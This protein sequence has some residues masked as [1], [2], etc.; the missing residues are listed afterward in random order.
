MGSRTFLER[1]GKR[2]ILLGSTVDEQADAGRGSQ[3][4]HSGVWL[5]HGQRIQ[6]DNPFPGDVQRPL[7]RD[8]HSEIG[9][10]RQHGGDHRCAID[11]LLEVVQ[12]HN[13]A[14]FAE[15]GANGIDKVIPHQLQCLGYFRW[16][17]GRV[18]HRGQ[19]YEN[20]AIGTRALGNARYI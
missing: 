20:R 16:H 18:G 4:V 11:H 9:V 12:H 13:A 19:R 1:I 10:L 15:P 8:K 14:P 6:A 5:G 7:G 3:F 17:H 2:D